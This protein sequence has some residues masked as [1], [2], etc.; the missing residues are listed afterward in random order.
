M[1]IEKLKQLIYHKVEEQ[2]SREVQYDDMGNEVYPL[3]PSDIESLV[4]VVKFL[5]EQAEKEGSD[6]PVLPT[7]LPM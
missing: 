3:K 1:D 7:N 2:L 4:R 5:G 6:I